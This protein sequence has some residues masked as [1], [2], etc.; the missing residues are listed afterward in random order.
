MS[1][2]NKSLQ[3]KYYSRGCGGGGSGESGSGES[4]SRESCSGESDNSRR[5]KKF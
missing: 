1:N 2:N 3:S 4:D 5:C